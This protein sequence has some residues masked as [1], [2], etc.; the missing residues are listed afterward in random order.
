[1]RRERFDRINIVPFVD[2][3]LVLLVIV[4]ATATFL[5]QG[6][7]PIH[8]PEGNTTTQPIQNPI[9]LTIDA[10]GSYYYDDKP[11]TFDQ[12]QSHLNTLDTNQTLLLRTDRETPFGYFSRL[13]GYLKRRGFEQI[14]IATQKE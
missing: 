10:N 5:K 4:L 12:L 2:I 7:V 9:T 13:A 11:A 1:M 8:L 14:S 6:T 3:V